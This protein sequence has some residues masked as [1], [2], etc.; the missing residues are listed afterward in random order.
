[1]VGVEVIVCVGVGR[2]SDSARLDP[3]R[4]SAISRGVGDDDPDRD[5]CVCRRRP[6]WRRGLL[7]QAET[8][9]V[10]YLRDTMLD[11]WRDGGEDHDRD[12]CVDGQAV[13]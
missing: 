13:A 3:R 8:T 6:G 11:T 12:H 7:L 4:C 2:G 5:Q 9:K 1:V 10:E